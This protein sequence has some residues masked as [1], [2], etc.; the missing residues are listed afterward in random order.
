M[1]PLFDQVAVA[2]A[3][4]YTLG[5]SFVG[6][7]DMVGNVWEW[8]AADSVLRTGQVRHIIKGGAFNT[9]PENAAASY[10]AMLPDDRDQLWNTGFRCAQSEPGVNRD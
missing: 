7:L 3:G 9:P 6:A 1:D 10:R 2:L 8:V 4:R 5:R